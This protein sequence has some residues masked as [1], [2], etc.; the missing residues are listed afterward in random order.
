V[1]FKPERLAPVLVHSVSAYLHNP[2]EYCRKRFP[3]SRI[4]V[5]NAEQDGLINR[6]AEQQGSR[7][8]YGALPRAYHAGFVGYHRSGAKLT[9]SI[10]QQ[11]DR[12][13]AMTTEEMNA[14]AH[15][16]PDHQVVDLDAKP[17]PPTRMI[18]WP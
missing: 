5:G 18:I 7:I 14:A 16:Y 15:S 1:S 13:L 8:A 3:R 12:I 9:G 2:I 10:D 4:P 17:G 6:V 11:A